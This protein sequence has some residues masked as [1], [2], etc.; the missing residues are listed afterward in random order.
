MPGVVANLAIKSFR[1]YSDSPMIPVVLA[2]LCLALAGCSPEDEPV[3]PGTDGEP[4]V[5]GPPTIA[6]VAPATFSSGRVIL[7]ATV[8]AN[9]LPTQ[10]FFQY[11][12]YSGF[13]STY[14]IYD[15][16]TPSKPI[17][18]SIDGV[19][20]CDTVSG[21]NVDTTYHFRC[22]A[23]NSEGTTF[24]TERTFVITA[25]PPVISSLISVVPGGL[26][27]TVSATVRPNGLE[28]RCYFEYGQTTSYGNQ[29]STA[30]IGAGYSDSVVSGTIAVPA[31]GTTTH[32][33]LVA[34]NSRGRIESAD[35]AFSLVEFVYPLTVGTWWKYSYE[36]WCLMGYHIIPGYIGSHIR[37]TQTWTVVK[38]GSPD[39]VC[40]QVSRID[41]VDRYDQ[42]D[43]VM[44]S[45][46]SFT[47][48]ISNANYR[49]R[50][51]ELILA[52]FADREYRENWFSQLI[53]V[54]RYLESGSDP[55]TNGN[56]GGNANSFFAR[57][58]NGK[59]LVSFRHSSAGHSS[60]N[61]TLTLDS[62]YV[63][64]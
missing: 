45:V 55:L 27:V 18:E 44:T 52:P 21:L 25:A 12:V 62:V 5:A 32:C 59:G 49:V 36:E 8:K 38:T 1:R 14:S 53:T 33:R 10:C 50:W 29:L 41:S 15:L 58:V 24:G 48:S 43:S 54:P 19:V 51:Y 9:S 6:S 47:V 30:S 34:M 17:G 63:A 64:P 11:G 39:S 35:R 42:S 40:I 28:T 4:P 16:Q 26:Q 3:T 57:Y 2:V 22:V 31:P 13:N 37:G 20:V 7:T 46:T 23:R 60:V 56:D 61:E